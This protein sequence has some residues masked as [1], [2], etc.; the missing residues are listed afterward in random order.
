MVT[1]RSAA[2]KNTNIYIIWYPPEKKPIKLGSTELHYNIHCLVSFCSTDWFQAT[3]Y[4]KK[5]SNSES[6]LQNSWNTCTYQWWYIRGEIAVG[7]CTDNLFGVVTALRYKEIKFFPMFAHFLQSWVLILLWMI[8][9][10]FTESYCR[11]ILKKFALEWD[12]SCVVLN[13]LWASKSHDL[14][15]IERGWDMFGRRFYS[16]PDLPRTGNTKSREQK[17]KKKLS[18]YT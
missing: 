6:R 15:S 13:G 14:N 17:I 18:F 2:S 16:L 12:L 7:R 9:H 11:S 3:V 4:L 10:E 5:N 8:M 1:C